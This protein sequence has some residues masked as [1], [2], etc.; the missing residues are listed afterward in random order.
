MNGL[1]K[2]KI[3]VIFGYFNTYNSKKKMT[4]FFEN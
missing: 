4:K 1:N 2:C 3:R